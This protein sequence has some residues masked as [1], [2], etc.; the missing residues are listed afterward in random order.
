MSLIP[1]KPLVISP[2]LASTIGLEEA[3]LLHLLQ[4][5]VSHNNAVS[6]NGFDWTTIPSERLLSLTPFWG[7]EDIRRFSSSLHEKGLLLI[8]G[9]PF[10]SNQDFRFAFNEKSKIQPD[11]LAS[12]NNYSKTVLATKPNSAKTIGV[13]WQPSFDALRQ[14]AQLGVTKEFALQQNRG[15]NSLGDLVQAHQ[16]SPADGFHN[17]VKYLSHLKRKIPGD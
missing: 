16:R 14:L 17:V 15:V 4:E 2:T 1:E 10:S 5:C 6:S 8:G 7:E 12:H 13:N 3:I 11:S 9:G